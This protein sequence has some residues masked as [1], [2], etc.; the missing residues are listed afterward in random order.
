[1]AATPLVCWIALVMTEVLWGDRRDALVALVLLLVVEG[2]WLAIIFHFSPWLGINALI[3]GIEKNNGAASIAA[4]GA[5]LGAT[6]SIACSTFVLSTKPLESLGYRLLGAVAF[7]IGWW[8]I[9]RFTALS[10]QITVD[11][12][13][14]AAW[15]LSAILIVWGLIAGVLAAMIGR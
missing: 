9:E 11:R 1:L 14:R 7:L 15:R 5:M 10:E 6:L 12:D 3:D 13:H 8:V 4:A 2:A